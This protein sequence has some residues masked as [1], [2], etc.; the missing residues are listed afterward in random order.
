MKFMGADVLLKQKQL[1]M[2][3]R[4]GKQ[5]KNYVPPNFNVIYSTKDLSHLPPGLGVISITFTFLN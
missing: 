2:I 3:K 1:C 4:E 5:T